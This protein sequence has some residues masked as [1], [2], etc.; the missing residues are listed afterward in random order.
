MHSH[1]V[2]VR[3]TEEGISPHPPVK[4][5]HLRQC[6]NLT[7][8]SVG[9]RVSGIVLGN[10]IRQ[11]DHLQRVHV[12]RRDNDWHNEETSFLL[13]DTDFLGQQITQHANELEEFSIIGLRTKNPP[14]DSLVEALCTVPSLSSVTI[15]SNPVTVKT[16]LS[17][18]SL[19]LLLAQATQQL[20]ISG[21]F[22]EA[23]EYQRL[24]LRAFVTEKSTTH[25][26]LHFAGTSAPS[27]FCYFLRHAMQANQTLQKQALLQ[28]EQQLSSSNGSSTPKKKRFWNRSSTSLSTSSTSTQPTQS[29]QNN[30]LI[31]S[32]TNASTEADSRRM[33]NLLQFL[34]KRKFHSLDAAYWMIRENPWLCRQDMG[35]TSTTRKW[36]WRG[37]RRSSSL[38]SSK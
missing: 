24:L 23:D 5:E 11:C 1:V 36:S 35:N 20:N 21:I 4:I 25:I 15:K 31:I 38:S 13:T 22:P 26:Y 32:S 16:L 7:V 29:Q 17:P 34:A 12:E 14:I 37:S 33:E 27:P 19:K 10:L 18:A 3:I 2:T 30:Q 6:R 9:A 28:Q 8:Y